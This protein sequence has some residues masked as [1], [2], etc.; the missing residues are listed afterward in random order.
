MSIHAR[1]RRLEA[2]TTA[3]C[4]LCREWPYER[5]GALLEQ[6]PEC[7]VCRRLLPGFMA[8]FIAQVKDAVD[9]AV[10]ETLSEEEL[11]TCIRVVDR[12][13]AV[14]PWDIDS[15]I[16][17]EDLEEREPG[18]FYCRTTGQFIGTFEEMDLFFRTATALDDA[19][20]AEATPTKKVAR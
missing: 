17:P 13:H 10:F 9:A 6:P 5:P 18:R 19:E 2:A 1:L 11:M 3:G 14:H 16:D 20:A 4:D 15:A 8:E 12:W 7:P